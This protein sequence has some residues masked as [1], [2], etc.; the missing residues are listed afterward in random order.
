MPQ[1]QQ[2]ETATEI[3]QKLGITPQDFL[4]LNPDFAAKGGKNDYLG[5]TGDLKVGQNYNL[6]GAAPVPVAPA[7]PVV[8][9]PLTIDTS[10]EPSSDTLTKY[11]SIDEIKK[12]LD[13]STA[14]IN[15]TLV[16][17]DA[18]TQLKT[19]LADIVAKEDAVNMGSKIYKNNLEG[20]GIS[21]G[22][23]QGRSIAQDRSTALTTE[24]LALQE[25]NLLTR[26]GLEAD[27]R[28][29]QTKIAENKYANVKDT[30]EYAAKAQAEIDKQK[31]ALVTATDKMTDNT[32]QALTT[33]LSQFKGIDFHSLSTEAQLKVQTMAN[34]LGIPID[35]IM[36]GME[37]NKNQQDL[38][39]LKKT[40]TSIP[41]IKSGSMVIQ[42]SSVAQGQG[43]LDASRGKPYKNEAGET[44]T[45]PATDKYANTAL[46]LQM[47]DAWKKDGGLEQDF[48]KNYPPKNYLNP[49]DPTIPQYIKDMLKKQADEEPL[50]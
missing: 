27:A 26:L 36:K 47:L 50:F 37:V 25:K 5:L 11:T 6:P 30:I 1:V 46:Y 23:I 40:A 39:N 4:K 33:I 12:M 18:E 19:Q 24:A 13:S 43:V 8:P 48:Y 2:N 3:V 22:A 34:S 49:S 20:E 17:T 29:V 32:R 42:E 45:P 21:S 9:T 44:I 10:K 14:D 15:K 38:E 35:V 7:G 16:P 28:G 41:T 31:A